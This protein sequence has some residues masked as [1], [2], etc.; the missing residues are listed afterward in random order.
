MSREVVSISKQEVDI[1][2]FIGAITREL[3]EI[4]NQEE[5]EEARERI[6]KT[7]FV[8][9]KKG[10]MHVD[11]PISFRYEYGYGHHIVSTEIYF[12]VGILR[13]KGS[14]MFSE[15]EE[16]AD[17][18]VVGDEVKITEDTP[19]FKRSLNLTKVRKIVEL[20]NYMHINQIRLLASLLF[21]D[22]EDKVYQYNPKFD[23]KEIR[24]GM[25]KILDDID[26][27]VNKETKNDKE[28]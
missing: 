7:C 20:I 27:I 16:N 6:Q 22:D 13:K 23:K 18:G 3:F 21:H 11:K 15:A 17:K 5:L 9:Y 26:N 12:G 4:R 8:L 24:V 28:A 2:N 10:L 14:L 25:K 19:A 1:S